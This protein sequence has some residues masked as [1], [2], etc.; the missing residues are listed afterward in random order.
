MGQLENFL[1]DQP[2]QTPVLLKA[3]LANVSQDKINTIGRAAASCQQIHR[4][5]L[6]IPIVTGRQV[7]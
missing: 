6:E 7:L 4:V 3:A 2:E 5:L 1:H